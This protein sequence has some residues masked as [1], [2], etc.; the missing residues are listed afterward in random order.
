[1]PLLSR[2]EVDFLLGK[3]EFTRDQGYYIKSRLLKKVKALYGIELPL[4]EERGYL[5]GSGVLAACSNDL[6]AT[7]RFQM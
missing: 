3:R 2:T 5:S 4:L 6:A 1:M 7:A